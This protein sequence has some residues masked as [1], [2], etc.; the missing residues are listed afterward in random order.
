[1]TV[2]LVVTY[3]DRSVAS[4]NAR[5]DAMLERGTYKVSA[6]ENCREACLQLA[7]KDDTWWMRHDVVIDLSGRHQRVGI[8]KVNP[9]LLDARK[10]QKRSDPNIR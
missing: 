10:R 9:G 5:C 1:M 2:M 4:I 7:K 3:D 6:V 8:I